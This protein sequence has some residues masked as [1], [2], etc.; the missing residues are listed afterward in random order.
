LEYP[1]LNEVKAINQHSMANLLELQLNLCTQDSLI[2]IPQSPA[3]FHQRALND[4][5]IML[6]PSIPWFPKSQWRLLVYP[7]GQ[8]LPHVWNPRSK[9]RGILLRRINGF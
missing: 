9:L 4:H 5:E 2:C 8:V 1:G 6:C 3:G 7:L